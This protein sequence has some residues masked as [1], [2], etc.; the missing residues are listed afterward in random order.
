MCAIYIP[1]SGTCGCIWYSPEAECQWMSMYY[2]ASTMLH[3]IDGQIV[4][5]Y[6]LFHFVPES[7]ANGLPVEMGP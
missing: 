1:T 3:M 2:K 6:D 4:T 7:E 5:N